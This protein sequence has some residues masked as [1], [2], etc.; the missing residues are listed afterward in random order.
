MRARREDIPVL[1]AHFLEVLSK[2]NDRRGLRFE[3]AAIDTLVAYSFPGNVRELKNLIERLVIL[4]PHDQISSE[5]VQTGLPGGSAA[6][7]GGLLRPGVPF[8]AP[9]HQAGPDVPPTQL[10]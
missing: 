3:P 4:T 8:P 9:L 10:P 2:Q 6:K 7:T 1:A 5:D